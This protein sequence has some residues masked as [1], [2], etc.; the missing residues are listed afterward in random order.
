MRVLSPGEKKQKM[1]EPGATQN[2]KNVDGAQL[3]KNIFWGDLKTWRSNPKKSKTS[4]PGA[5]AKFQ[6]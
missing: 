2:F 1:S 5:R 3:I 4:E 6:K